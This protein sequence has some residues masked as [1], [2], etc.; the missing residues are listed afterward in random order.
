[1]TAK[2]YI[3]DL[4][5]RL[6]RYQVGH[7]LS[8]EMLLSFI[9]KARASVQRVLLP[10]YPERFSTIISIPHTPASLNQ[11]LSLTTV[12]TL[13]YTNINVYTYVMPNW[14]IDAY[15]VIIQWT[16]QEQNIVQSH[17]RRHNLNEMYGLYSN[18]W[19]QPMISTYT[20][21]LEDNGVN[22]LMHIAGLDA[23][24]LVLQTDVVIN[25]FCTAALS[26]L[27]HITA[28]A[29]ANDTET[30]IPSFAEELVVTEALLYCFEVLNNKIALDGLRMEKQRLER[31]LILNYGT[32][33]QREEILLPSK[34]DNV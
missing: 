29:L 27:E 20:Y 3:D 30:V 34:A 18:S 26:D 14:F 10:M 31:S 32:K 7:D 1:M 9:N 24:G 25:I 6:T 19:N 4:K 23:I 33:Q 12:E 13:G 11:D 2:E 28:G 21:A 16:D 22:T 17:C 8:D 15:E 5:L